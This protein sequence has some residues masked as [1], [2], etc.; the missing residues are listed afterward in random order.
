MA[1]ATTSSSTTAGFARLAAA[2]WTLEYETG[3]TGRGVRLAL[4]CVLAVWLVGWLSWCY[5]VFFRRAA[6][7]IKVRAT[8]LLLLLLRSRVRVW[9]SSLAPLQS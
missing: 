8:G 6:G 4:L 1:P 2:R 9:S 3:A 7:G 5:A